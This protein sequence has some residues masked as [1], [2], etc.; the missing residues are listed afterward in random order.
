MSGNRYKIE[1]VESAP[2]A[3]V[4]Y[5]LWS[6]GRTE[7]LVVDPGFETGP[8][9]ELLERQGL[10]VAAILN[11]HGHVDHIAGNAALKQAFPAAPLVIGTNEA[12]LLT[13]PEANMSASFGIGFTSPPADRLLAEGDRFD[14]AGFSFAI[15][16]L[17]GHSPGSIVYICDQY[18]P[19]FVFVGDVI[20]AGS[21]GRADLDGDA[22][23]LVSGIKTKLFTLPDGTLL[24]PGHGPP[25]TVGQERRTNPYVGE[26]AGPREIG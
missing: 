1:P 16:E 8:V 3:Q 2:F 13:D 7:A 21:V 22:A 9:L 15:R 25:T 6:P 14:A 5:V 26:K 4:A 19:P 20:F 23:Q 24:L 17:P 11:T 12:R 10:T 18:D